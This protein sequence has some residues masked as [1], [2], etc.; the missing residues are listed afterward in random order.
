MDCFR[1][2]GRNAE[3]RSKSQVLIRLAEQDTCRRRLTACPIRAVGRRFAA[4][5]TELSCEHE[6]RSKATANDSLQWTWPGV[7]ADKLGIL[8]NE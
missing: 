1:E 4:T 5:N 6:K 7:Q 2:E 3:I 8:R